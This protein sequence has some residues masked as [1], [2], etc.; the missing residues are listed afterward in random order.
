MRIKICGINNIHDAKLA[1]KAGTDALGFLVGITHLAE[2]K[3]SNDEAKNIIKELPLFVSTVAVTHF[4]DYEEVINLV[5]FLNVTTLQ[6]HDY[7][8]PYK[9]KIISQ[10]LP[11]VK[12][13]KAIHVMDDNSILSAKKFEPYVDA[14]LLDSR[15]KDRLGG[16]GITH[17]WN[18]SAQIVNEMNKPVILAGGLNE[19][20]V[21]EAVRKVKP[22]GVDVNSGVEINSKKDFNK[23][24]KFIS[25]AKKSES[26]NY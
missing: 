3:V 7:I 24:C 25:E 9:V 10:T 4:T 19:I 20:N 22:F 15:T 1:I 6:I 8:E 5:K 18:I 14:I 23:I 12:I 11:G 13:I 16:T 21:Y 26:D 2:D 17:D